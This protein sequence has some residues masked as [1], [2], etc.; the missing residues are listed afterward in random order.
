MNINA[1]A[2]CESSQSVF[3]SG[4]LESCIEVPGQTVYVR[5]HY[6]GRGKLNDHQDPFIGVVYFEEDDYKYIRS[7]DVAGF[8]GECIENTTTISCIQGNLLL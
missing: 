8:P 7:I 1:A 3:L 5:G 6:N 4:N 2:T